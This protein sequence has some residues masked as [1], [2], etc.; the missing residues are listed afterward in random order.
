MLKGMELFMQNYTHTKS[1]NW[2]ECLHTLKPEVISHLVGRI[3]MISVPSRNSQVS[4]VGEIIRLIYAIYI[5]T[6]KP[7]MRPFKQ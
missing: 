2:V 5:F 6:R 3:G 1:G 4:T 7:Y